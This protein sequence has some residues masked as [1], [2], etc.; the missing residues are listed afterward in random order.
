MSKPLPFV[1]VKNNKNSDIL[2]IDIQDFINKNKK[3]K[4]RDFDYVVPEQVTNPSL[5][6]DWITF[7]VPFIFKGHINGGK[8]INISK[9]GDIEYK[10][11][12]RLAVKGSYDD[13]LSIRT[14][15]ILP[16]GDT[17]LISV[18]GNPVKWFQGHNIFGT[19]DLNG[20]VYETVLAISDILDSKQDKNILNHIF[21]GG[22][23]ISRVDINGMYHL[24][25]RNEVLSWLNT[26]EKTGRS[27][28]GTALSKGNTVYF[29]KNSG[30]WSIKSYSKGQE[31]E[32]HKLPREL[33]LDSLKDFAD[34]KLRIELTLRQKELTKLGLN[35]GS[36]WLDIDLWELYKEYARRIEMSGQDS[37]LDDKLLE[38]PKP[39]RQT[40]LTWSTGHNPR[41]YCSKAKF[42]RHRKVLLD[43]GIDIS[44]L[45]TKDV[46]DNVI[47]LRRVLEL[48]P[49]GIPEWAYGTNLLFEPRKAVK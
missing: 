41:Q 39:V 16:E 7:K 35:R 23:S 37:M 47:P 44:V 27:R 30:R 3:I 4:K 9:D 32:V 38:L 21:N 26:A 10:I 46:V 11:D 15:R 34:N 28:H 29:G 2:D 13:S 19:D 25:N 31:L 5:M 8:I 1:F 20:L 18:S 24:K 36:S 40:Y 14:E 43:Y 49:C 33:D 45:K 12:K 17:W 6:I 48:K 22:Y 42:Y